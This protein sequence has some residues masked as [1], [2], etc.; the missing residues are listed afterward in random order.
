[1][2]NESDRSLLI[3]A[4]NYCFGELFAYIFR[5]LKLELLTQI[6]KYYFLS[7]IDI[8]QIELLDRLPHNILLICVAFNLVLNMM[9]S[10]HTTV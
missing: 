6:Q 5:H 2:V 10:V 9:N 4:L 3:I 7:N 1:M 8:S